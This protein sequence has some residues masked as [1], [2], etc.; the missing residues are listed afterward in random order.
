MTY[1]DWQLEKVKNCQAQVIQ[2]HGTMAKL[3]CDVGSNIYPFAS[4][5]YDI[6]KQG[7]VPYCPG[8]A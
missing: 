2:L 6:F 3:R 7:E 1:L 4:Q 5:Y 8:C